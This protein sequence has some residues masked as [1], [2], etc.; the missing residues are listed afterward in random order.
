MKAYDLDCLT[1]LEIS[2]S[3]KLQF[4]Y[5]VYIIFIQ[6]FKILKNQAR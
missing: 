1:I 2:V 5:V 6:T 3:A 4:T